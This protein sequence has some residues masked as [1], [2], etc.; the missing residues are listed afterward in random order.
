MRDATSGKR[1]P[2]DEVCHIEDVNLTSG[3][4]LI[5]VCQETRQEKRQQTDK[6]TTHFFGTYCNIQSSTVGKQ[7]LALPF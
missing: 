4:I 2:D 5:P 7:A 6:K 3:T 1:E